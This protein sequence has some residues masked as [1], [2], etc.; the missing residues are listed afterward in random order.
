MS[1]AVAGS[2]T[3]TADLGPLA[4]LHKAEVQKAHA[5]TAAISS[6]ASLT[7]GR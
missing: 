3:C 4:T 1:S 2:R 7:D 6:C 5:V